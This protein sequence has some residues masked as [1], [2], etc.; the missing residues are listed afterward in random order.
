MDEKRITKNSTTVAKIEF[1]KTFADE[2]IAYSK[3]EKLKEKIRQVLKTNIPDLKPAPFIPKKDLRLQEFTAIKHFYTSADFERSSTLPLI[4]P[5]TAYTLWFV[6]KT[7][8]YLKW[9]V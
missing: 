7:F 3:D 6:K 8:N 5:M 1:A 2:V 9:F 4:I